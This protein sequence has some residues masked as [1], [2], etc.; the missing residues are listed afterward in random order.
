MGHVHSRAVRTELPRQSRTADKGDSD[1]IWVEVE[2]SR[3]ADQGGCRLI[4]TDDDNRLGP[5]AA[6]VEQGDFDRLGIAR[7]VRFYDQG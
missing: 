1:K 7:I 4:G 3:P 5:G 6:Q 2:A